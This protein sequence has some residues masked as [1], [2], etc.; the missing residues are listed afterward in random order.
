VVAAGG[1]LATYLRP[2][3]QFGAGDYDQILLTLPDPF[4]QSDQPRNSPL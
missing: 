4:S 1:P 3:R 2:L